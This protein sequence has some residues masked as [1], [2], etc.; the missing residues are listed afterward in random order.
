MPLSDMRAFFRWL[1][2]ASDVEISEKRAVLMQFIEEHRHSD[3]SRK[4]KSLVRYIDEEA[5][6]RK[7][8]FE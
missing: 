8:R 6:A 1:D 2:Q 7:L 5:L 3:V 4:A